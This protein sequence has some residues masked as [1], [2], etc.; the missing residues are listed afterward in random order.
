MAFNFFV[1]YGIRENSSSRLVGIGVMLDGRA[2]KLLTSKIG[3]FL[4][5]LTCAELEYFSCKDIVS[6]LVANVDSLPH[7]GHHGE[8]L[9]T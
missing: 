7:S 3:F 4:G 8:N 2:Y 5:A 9:I 6:V 1:I